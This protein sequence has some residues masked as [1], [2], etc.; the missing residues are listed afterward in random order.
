MRNSDVPRVRPVHFV[1]PITDLEPHL[2]GLG[3]LHDRRHRQRVILPE[4]ARWAKRTGRQRAGLDCN[5]LAQN[6]RFCVKV[7]RLGRIRR[8]L[9]HQEEVLALKDDA[10]RRRVHQRLD[11]VRQTSVLDIPRPV[12][13][14]TCHQ[15]LVVGVRARR[16]GRGRVDHHRRPRNGPRHVLGIPQIARAVLDAANLLRLW[17]DPDIQHLDVH[18]LKVLQ[19]LLDDV[20]PEEPGPA[21]HADRQRRG[22][23]GR[24]PLGL[25]RRQHLRDALLHSHT[26]TFAWPCSMQTLCL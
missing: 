24:S 19:T 5:L 17:R 21:S 7:H 22:L 3:L 16:S 14:H 4:Y 6:L 20:S 18:V 15:L 13:I 1:R 26:A 12:H 9:V 11:P 23:V 2:A 8:A 10:G 25:A